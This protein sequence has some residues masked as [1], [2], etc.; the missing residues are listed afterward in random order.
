MKYSTN[1][2][3]GAGGPGTLHGGGE[4]EE[5]EDCLFPFVRIVGQEEMK[6]ALLLNIVDPKIGGVLIRGEKGTAKSTTVRSLVQ[7]LPDVVSSKGCRFHCSVDS[8]RWMCEDCRRKLAEGTLVGERR[9]MSVVE[10]PLNATEDRISGSLDLE[11]ILSSGERRYEGG[12]LAK[13]NGNLLYVDEVNLLDDHIVDLLL[14]SAA[15]G[16]NYVERE[17]VSFSHPSRFVLVGTMNPEEGSLRPQLLDRFGMCT[18]VA[19]DRDPEVR[20]EVIRR[21]LEFDDDPESYLDSCAGETEELRRRLADARESLGDVRLPDDIVHTVAVVSIRF[22]LEG[23]RAD[24]AMIRA[25]KANAA[26][27]GRDEVT[28]DDIAETAGLVLRHRLKGGP[29][30]EAQF[31]Q[32]D[33]LRYM[34]GYR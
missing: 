20:M 22:G 4:M 25:A 19:G 26:L 8:P 32:T 29:F 1:T 17:G 30:E 12:V 23:H 28:S 34:R 27:D 33:L 3:G 24:L 18:D 7:I 11:H 21:R 16:R 9:R 2:E 13:A 6:R 14:D 10:L 5:G 31:S 15:M